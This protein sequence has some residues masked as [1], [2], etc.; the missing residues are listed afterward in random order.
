M[1]DVFILVD[2]AFPP[3]ARQLSGLRLALVTSRLHQAAGAGLGRL[4]I[5]CD[6]DHVLKLRM[7]KEEAAHRAVEVVGEVLA[8]ATDIEP[9]DTRLTL[10][11]AAH[12]AHFTVLVEEVD[13]LVVQT[14][15][16]EI[17]VKVL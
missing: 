11:D 2:A 6:V 15:V 12:E 17:A 7:V 10:E 3:L 5:G 8:E 14:F 16:D 9:T 13:R 4:A 1:I